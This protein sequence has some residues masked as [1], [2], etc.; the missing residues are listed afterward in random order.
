MKLSLLLTLYLLIFV[1]GLFAQTSETYDIATFT[2]PA[3]W[4][5]QTKDGAVMFT[6][7]DE[8]NG[9]QHNRQPKARNHHSP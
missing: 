6:T 8:K 7:A 5:K 2:P 3:L 9:P 4:K 1:T